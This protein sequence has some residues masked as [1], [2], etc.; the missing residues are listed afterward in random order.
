MLV[1]QEFFARSTS[2]SKN[3]NHIP[4]L[5]LDR[6]QNLST[7]PNNY[8]RKIIQP[9][10]WFTI[11]DSLYSSA[12]WRRFDCSAQWIKSYWNTLLGI[13][14]RS[15]YRCD[16]TSMFQYDLKSYQNTLR[17]RTV[18]PGARTNTNISSCN[19]LC[20]FWYDTSPYTF[21]HKIVDC[22]HWTSKRVTVLSGRGY[23]TLWIFKEL[24]EKVRLLSQR[25]VCI[26]SQLW[27]IVN[28]DS[29]LMSQ[30]HFVL[31]SVDF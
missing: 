25:H 7:D 11:K 4:Y 9:E 29:I 2:V 27:I 23:H 20:V 13:Q 19:Y 12:Y 26:V 1:Y 30:G 3:R 31:V 5:S 15:G 16:A 24:D 8:L 18:R 28:S 22:Y 6:Y 10:M 17:N 14:P 21:F